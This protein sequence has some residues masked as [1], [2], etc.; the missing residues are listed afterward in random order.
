[1]KTE[2]ECGDGESTSGCTQNS[3]ITVDPETGGITYN[4]EFYVI[5]H[6]A[7]FIQPGARRILLSGPWKSN[8]VAFENPDA[9]T[10]LVIKNPGIESAGMQLQTLTSLPFPLARWFLKRQP[11]RLQG[12]SIGEPTRFVVWLLAGKT[13]CSLP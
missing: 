2:N 9:T 5:K 11:M 13:Q 3:M 10:A 4:P 8:T 12:A 1:M 7:R 6:F